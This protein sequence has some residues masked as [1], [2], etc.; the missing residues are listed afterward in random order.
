MDKRDGVVDSLVLNE[1][2]YYPSLEKHQIEDVS[3]AN[4]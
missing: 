2:K 4:N 1:Q 3:S